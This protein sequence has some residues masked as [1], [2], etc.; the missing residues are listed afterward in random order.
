MMMA[1]LSPW[2]MEHTF[3]SDCSME[4]FQAL[5]GSIARAMPD[6]LAA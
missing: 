6:L 5:G 3:V 2:A 4:R 1:S